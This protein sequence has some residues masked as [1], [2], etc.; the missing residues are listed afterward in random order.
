M[1]SPVK[2]LKRARSAQTR[3][4]SL[5]AALI[6]GFVGTAGIKVAHAAI[7]FATSVVLAK[8]LGPSGYG[9]FT[10]VIALV[11]LLTIPS[12]LGIP[13]LSV[14]EV[15]VSFA[16][17]NWGRMR[18]FIIWAHRTVAV[19]S[20]IMIAFGAIG[21]YVWGD[22]LSP[23]KSACMWL[24]LLLIP[25]LSFGSL[26]DS[27]LRGLRYVVIGQ[28]SQPIIRPMLLLLGIL[29]FWLVGV[30]LASPERV[31]A[32]HVASV[33]M[34]FLCG[35]YLF[36]ARRPEELRGATPTFE[37]AVW[38]R[39]TIPFGMT[40]ALQ[41]INGRTDVLALGVFQTDEDVGI[42]RVAAQLA[43]VVIFGMQAVATVQGPHIAHLFAKGDM[44]K[45]QQ[46]MTRS[47]QAIMMIA[48]PA[49]L[50]IVVFGEQIIRIVYG[51]AF[52][53]AYVPLVILC[54]GQLVNA[55]MGSV[56]ALLNM[57]GHER[58]TTKSVLVGAVVN[59]LL[60]LSLV[61]VWG[62]TGAALATAVTLIVW[63]LIMWRKARLL[64]G[65]ETSLL[66]RRRHKGP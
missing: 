37:S 53:S 47:A 38:L 40:A 49:V 63:N 15:A 16:R 45:L 18:G 44:Q 35:L 27:M 22:G 17:K 34:A 10:F 31:M 51:P 6:R 5:G 48:I 56:A 21:L 32:I 4:G 23:Q 11:A 57:T 64:T 60:N 33:G 13:N 28:L 3:P 61:P 2:F 26:R 36:F 39:S 66:F 20:I 62:M 42:Y 1:F 46:L 58:E 65:I 41:L 52:E 14:R 30:D 59:L 25:L 9:I 12:E 19:T 43:I 54:V 8:L 24:A 50:V 7:A 55:S 29:V